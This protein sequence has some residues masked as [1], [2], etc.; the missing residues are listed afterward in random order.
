[1]VLPEGRCVIF[2]TSILEISTMK[3]VWEP[4]FDK[5]ILAIDAR[6]LSLSQSW[7]FLNI[8]YVEILERIS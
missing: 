6:I 2:C 8:K 5:Y 3:K 4:S 7:D 1:M